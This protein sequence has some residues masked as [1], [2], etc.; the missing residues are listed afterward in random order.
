MK[1]R[2]I[3]TQRSG[4]N[5]KVTGPVFSKTKLSKLAL[6]V[7]R[8]MPQ[9]ILTEI[10]PAQADAIQKL[11]YRVQLLPNAHLLKIGNYTINT[12]D[13]K[14]STTLPKELTLNST[15]LKTWT[16]YLVQFMAPPVQS[17]I[18]GVETLGIRVI[19]K[20]GECGLFVTG[21]PATIARLKELDTIAWY[22]PFEPAYRVDAAVLKM[23]GKIKSL[24]IGVLGTAAA[25]DVKKLLTDG[26]A[27][28]TLEV[29]ADNLRGE[30]YH[31]FVAEADAKLLLTLATHP[32]VRWINH[33]VKAQPDDERT[34]QITAEALDA[35]PAPNTLPVTGY[36]NKLTEFGLTGGTGVT[37]TV[38][39]SGIDT[40]DASPGNPTLHADLRG[41][42]A[43]FLDQTAGIGTTDTNGHGTHVAG[44]IAGNATTGNADPQGFLLGMGIA[45]AAQIGS[46]NAI[47][48]NGT[49]NLTTMM[50]SCVTNNSEIVNNSWNMGGPNLGYTNNCRTIDSGIRDANTAAA[51]TQQLHFIFSAG[52][53]GNSATNTLTTPH[54]IKNGVVVGNSLNARPGEMFPSDDIRGIFSSSSRGPSLDGR[55]FPT[56]VAPGTNVISTRSSAS[57]NAS[58]Q[59]TGG[60]SHAQHTEKTGTSMST[61]A[62]T[63]LGALFIE[64]WR[65]RTAGQTP[66]PALLKAALVNGAIDL[67][68]GQNWK[69]LNNSQSPVDTANWVNHAGNVYRRP[70]PFAPAQLLFGNTAMTLQASL[71]NVNAA[72]RWF[73]DNATQILYVWLTG[74][75]NPAATNTGVNALH[76][77][78]LTAIPN[79][80]QGWGRVSLENILIQTTDRGPKIFFDRNTADV[81]FT[82]NGQSYV[83]E[84]IVVDRNKPLR[85]T[86]AYSDAPGAANANPAIVN[87]LNLEVE[88]ILGDG[89]VGQLYLGNVFNAAGFSATGGTADALNNLECVYIQNPISKYRVRIVAT[90]VTFNAQPPFTNATPWQ[91]FAYVI[92]NAIRTVDN[93]VCV[94]P[95]IDR[96][97]SMVNYGYVDITRVTT[98]N[99]IDLLSVNDSTAVVS[100]GSTATNEYHNAGNL[101]TIN[102]TTEKDNAKNA[103]DAIA[104]GGCTYMGQ[105]LQNGRNLLNTG[106]ADQEKAIVLL[107]DGYDNG[108]CNSANPTAL[109]IVNA[110][111]PA[112]M[113]VYTCA[114]GA[115]ADAASL[116]EIAT[117]TNGRYYMMPD[118]DDL[119][120]IYNYIRGQ[121][122][123]A[124]ESIIT[125]T[126]AFASYA[127]VKSFVEK[128]AKCV[129][130]SVNWFT[131]NLKF[132]PHAPK[133]NTQ[134]SV[135]LIDPKGRKVHPQSTL[136]SRIVGKSYVIL[137]IEEPAAG[138]WTIEVETTLKTHTRF[139]VGGFVK[140]P[141]RL[142][143][144]STI[145][146]MK[147]G[148]NF[149]LVSQLLI[150]DKAFAGG[151]YRVN[152]NIPSGNIRSL[153]EKH[154]ADLKKIDPGKLDKDSSTDFRK[155]QL[156]NAQLINAGKPG[157]FSAGTEITPT[158]SYASLKEKVNNATLADLLK[159]S[160]QKAP[161]LAD[162]PI[163]NTAFNLRNTGTFNAVINITGTT[164]DNSTRF[165]RKDMISVVSV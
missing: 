43:F 149:N 151:N 53:A 120:E 8:E 42:L 64:W 17:W 58:Y 66:T 56:V 126:S 16:H 6:P 135:R 109:S 123:D 19:E 156:L 101:V 107:S 93:P 59:D 25:A 138:N 112:N 157:I 155:L 127:T 3:I 115:A 137:R 22:G 154:A 62:V 60:T 61:P 89:S 164:P 132:T 46:I 85:V 119:G 32:A 20:A 70:L 98:K 86:M 94:V 49:L 87:N 72:G 150:N 162:G 99:F 21:A 130:F 134:I 29:P 33:E 158:I 102:S 92:D 51:G 2:A 71:A 82:A 76:P 129:T 110:G 45:P 136:V 9:G 145:Q 77:N 31:T 97:G 28:I 152:L 144:P 104:F 153:L 13:L 160:G 68:G 52:N 116:Q 40:N 38:C 90:S 27:R 73:Y 139:T 106:P 91:D 143:I 121:I 14:K 141:I 80:D 18:K 39:D 105:G 118:I 111:W 88:E 75:V 100:F 128:G 146:L 36:Q 142:Y 67:V 108:G 30:I 23:S 148:M 24:S 63:G 35:T 57:G 113:P 7:L 44:I 131:E 161:K 11:G 159:A 79:N 74:N 5:E 165:V 96:S 47:D 37:V 50:Q 10:E 103:V 125:N 133:S 124:D 54:E 83:R 81:V 55:L 48:V 41:R 117:R 95:V 34:A 1:T 114:M 65:N 69:R 78:A 122:A 15:A 140:S 26:K 163:Y 84:I 147:K 12:A 4:Q